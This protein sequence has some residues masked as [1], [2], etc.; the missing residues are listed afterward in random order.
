MKASKLIA[1]NKAIT[2]PNTVFLAQFI[3][4]NYLSFYSKYSISYLTLSTSAVSI[5]DVSS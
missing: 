3:L 4:D 1:I 2:I 5:Y